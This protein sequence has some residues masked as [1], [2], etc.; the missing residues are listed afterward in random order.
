MKLPQG[1]I[2]LPPMGTVVKGTRFL[3]MKVPLSSKYDKNVKGKASKRFEINSMLDN[4]EEAHKVRV[5]AVVDLTN[6]DRYYDKLQLQER[7]IIHIKIAMA[8]HSVIPPQGDVEAFLSQ[9]SDVQKKHSS[10]LIIVHCTHGH[11]RTG[12][13]ICNY[14]CR[15]QNKGPA[16]A[17]QLFSNSRYP[18]IYKAAYI[19][20]LHYIFS[21]DQSKLLPYS[22]PSERAADDE[23]R[24][25]AVFKADGSADPVA[26]QKLRESVNKSLQTKIPGKLVVTYPEASW[27][28]FDDQHQKPP[29]N[30]T[31]IAQ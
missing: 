30:S 12:Y 17:L 27:G 26:M 29:T 8:G 11:N 19:D 13:M 28:E 25:A 18:G 24:S 10:G 9:V 5:V 14:L 21:R 3:P 15:Y 1:W 7:G 6:T 22:Y 31:C 4:V 20:A 23:G 16:E 2:D